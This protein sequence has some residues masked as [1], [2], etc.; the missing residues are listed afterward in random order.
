MLFKDSLEA[1]KGMGTYLHD[2]TYEHVIA[3]MVDPVLQ[4]HLINHRDEDLV[5]KITGQ[6]KRV[7]KRLGD[8]LRWFSH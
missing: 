4:H 6:T 5:L 3:L 7:N 1:L 8:C 2:A